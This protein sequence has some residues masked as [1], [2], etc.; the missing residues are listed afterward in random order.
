M[1]PQRDEFTSEASYLE[2]YAFLG[3]FRCVFQVEPDAIG[4]RLVT[5]LS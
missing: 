4:W 1:V 2:I 5:R 3:A